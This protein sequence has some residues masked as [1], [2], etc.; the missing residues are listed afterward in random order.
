MALPC[1]ADFDS[2]ARCFSEIDLR[3][4]A[5]C[6]ENTYRRSSV[7]VWLMGII[8]GVKDFLGGFQ[9]TVVADRE[10]TTPRRFRWAVF[11]I[12]V[13]VLSVL[14]WVLIATIR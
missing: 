3:V 13:V 8:Q 5:V 6:I 10:M 4:M 1:A 9:E 12:L 2:L 7:R 11:V 14:I